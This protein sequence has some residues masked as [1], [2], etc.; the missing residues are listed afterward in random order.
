MHYSTYI[1]TR[2][3]IPVSFRWQQPVG[4]P[5]GIAFS[6]ASFRCAFFTDGPSSTKSRLFLTRQSRSDHPLS[7]SPPGDGPK[8]NPTPAECDGT[9]HRARGVTALCTGPV[10]KYRRRRRRVLEE[11]KPQTWSLHTAASRR[12]ASDEAQLSPYERSQPDRPTELV[13]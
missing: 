7:F 13:L 2:A 5:V 6:P 3:A 8:T 1:A 4:K 12:P 10:Q 11:A 9:V